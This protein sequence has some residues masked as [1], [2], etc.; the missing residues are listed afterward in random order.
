MVATSNYAAVRARDEKMDLKGYERLNS[1]PVNLITH[2]DVHRHD[3]SG[4]WR[5]ESLV[6]FEETTKR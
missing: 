6:S 1:A 4:P 5:V 2:L 3:D